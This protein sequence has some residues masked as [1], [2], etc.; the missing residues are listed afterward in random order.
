MRNLLRGVWIEVED[1]LLILMHA[2]KNSSRLAE[3]YPSVCAQGT[4]IRDSR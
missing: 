4:P 1:L 3:P 2:R